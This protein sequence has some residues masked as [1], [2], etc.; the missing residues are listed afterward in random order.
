MFSPFLTFS[1]PGLQWAKI[2]TAQLKKTIFVDLEDSGV[3]IDFKEIE[4]AFS[5]KVIETK[6]KSTANTKKKAVTLLDSKTSQNLCEQF[7]FFL[8][9]FSSFFSHFIVS[10]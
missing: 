3:S 4:K 8:F 7:T 5:A 10:V 6:E 9:L 1:L 2:P